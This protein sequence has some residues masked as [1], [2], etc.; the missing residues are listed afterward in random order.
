MKLTY[1]ESKRDDLSRLKKSNFLGHIIF[2]IECSYFLT[3]L[4]LSHIYKSVKTT[5]AP[6]EETK[7]NMKLVLFVIRKCTINTRL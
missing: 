4:F 5:I 6:I 3:A 1:E 7:L 2:K